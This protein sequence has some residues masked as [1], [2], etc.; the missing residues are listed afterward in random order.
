MPNKETF[1]VRI[2]GEHALKWI[3]SAE[4]VVFIGWFTDHDRG[5]F[6]VPSDQLS[7]LDLLGIQS[8]TVALRIRKS[9]EVS[10][11]NLDKLAWTLRFANLNRM[12]CCWHFTRVGTEH[13]C[14]HH[15]Q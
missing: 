14:L 9:D 1:S 15:N 12:S 13:R 10:P 5:W 6:A 8:K 11:D 2:R 3:R 7:E 4:P